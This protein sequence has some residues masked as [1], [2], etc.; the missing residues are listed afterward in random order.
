[1]FNLSLCSKFFYAVVHKN[2]CLD[3]K[4]NDSK[5][6]TSNDLMILGQIRCFFACTILLS[7]KGLV[8]IFEKLLFCVSKKSWWMK[9]CFDLLT[10][11]HLLFCCR[12]LKLS[13]NVSIGLGLMLK[14]LLLQNIRGEVNRI[15][16][17]I[18]RFSRVG[19]RRKR[20]IQIWIVCL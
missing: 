12:V 7:V 13:I 19:D 3:E 4:M 8:G 1:M 10:Y 11:C 2:T 17:L 18:N 5:H 9:F 20:D 16:M 6:L 14:I 15:H